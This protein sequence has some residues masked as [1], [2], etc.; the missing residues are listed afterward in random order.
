[1]VQ[2]DVDRDPLLDAF[3]PMFEMTSSRPTVEA[4]A[5]RGNRLAIARVFW[6][7]A[8]LSVGPSEIEWLSVIEVGDHGDF[9]ETVTFDPGDLD[10][11]HAEVDRR[12]AAGEAAGCG[13][14]SAAMR[15]FCG[16]FAARDWESLA[17]GFAPGLFV[18]DRRRL[19]WETLQGPAAYVAS[20]R[21]LVDLAPDTRLR[22]DHVRMS[23][24]GL[25]WVAAW[26]GTREGGGFETPWII[27]SEHD[28]LGRVVRFDQYDL[29][30]LDEAQARFE[31]LRPDS[32][33]SAQ[34]GPSPA[35]PHG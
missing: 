10:A 13:R 27:V 34:R 20:L 6:K 33:R 5:T 29:D 7:G 24:R 18:H 32:P 21:S 2:L 8:D 23:D 25:L 12:Y 35:R 14:V 22:L 19:G 31:E 28:D 1:M 4:V 9:A 17:A 15:A 16:A 11:A 3:R 30:Q 26:L